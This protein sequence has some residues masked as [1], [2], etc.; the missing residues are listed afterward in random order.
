VELLV[1]IG[2][3]ALLI[4]VLLPALNSARKQA[5]R[6]K[7]LSALKQI[8]NAYFMYSNENKG[9]WPV[10]NHYWVNAP[11]GGMPTQRDKRWHDFIGKY[12]MGPTAVTDT[13]T[14]TQYTDTQC[15]FNG[16]AGFPQIT[17]YATWGEFGTQWDPVYVGTFRDRNNVLWG[18]PS[19]RRVAGTSFNLYA[20]PGYT[21]NYHALAPKDYV[22]ALNN[23]YFA[24]R[25]YINYNPA[26]G[27]DRPGNYFKQSQWT[28]AGERALILESVH[29]NLNTTM[30]TS[31][32]V[33][34]SWPFL[35]EGTTVFPTVPN[36]TTWSFDFNRHGKRDVGNAP[37]DP[38]M[39]MLYCDGHAAFVSSRE[40]YRAIFFK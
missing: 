13:A 38:S 35:P 17:N 27:T 2:I 40:A 14:G 25:A 26:V 23:A 1:V 4:S 16:T 31:A 18:C 11:A 7:C 33:L 29:A 15:N 36:Q 28:R 20:H 5:D 39:N 19:W 8:G 3:I 21:M 32:A 6:V 12:L 22:G 37:N 9:Y 34:T 10:A 30:P 24:K